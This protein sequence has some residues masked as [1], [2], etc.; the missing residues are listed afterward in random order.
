MLMVLILLTG[1]T[2]AQTSCQGVSNLKVIKTTT[3]SIS[4]GWGADDTRTQCLGRYRVCALTSSQPS[5]CSNI[6][7]EST[8]FVITGLVPCTNY[9][10]SV[11][12][13]LPSAAYRSEQVSSETGRES[14]KRRTEQ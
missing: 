8:E 1:L 10:V 13:A 3:Y 6:S 2:A 4:V 7:M 12:L 11:E 14:L 9:T 5:T